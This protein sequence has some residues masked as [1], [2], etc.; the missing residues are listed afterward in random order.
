MLHIY[1]HDKKFILTNYKLT[2]VAESMNFS[3]MVLVW[4]NSSPTQMYPKVKATL[5][6]TFNQK[7]ESIKLFR[8]NQLTFQ[9]YLLSIP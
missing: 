5:S 3:T 6:F 9:K 2:S 1:F 8:Q 4:G 7:H